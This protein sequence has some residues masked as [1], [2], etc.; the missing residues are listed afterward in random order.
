[1]CGT[2]ACVSSEIDL[3]LL[4]SH[5]LASPSRAYRYLLL[6]RNADDGCPLRLQM[7]PLQERYKFF[8][9][10]LECSS[11]SQASVRIQGVVADGHVFAKRVV[12]EKGEGGGGGIWT[13]YIV[14]SL[15]QWAC[16]P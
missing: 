2:P 7:A 4:Q 10:S 11:V 16:L 9:M 12:K 8:H 15:Y 14:I 6:W 3:W 5:G 13:C 1:M